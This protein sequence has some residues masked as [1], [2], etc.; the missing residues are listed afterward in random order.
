MAHEDRISALRAAFGERVR[1]LLTDAHGTIHCTTDPD[2]LVRLC[3]FL[4]DSDA[5]RCVYLSDLTAID[6][7]EGAPAAAAT[8]GDA[9]P[10]DGEGTPSPAK[11]ATPSK[12]EGHPTLADRGLFVVYCLFSL[13]H[14]FT[15]EIKA[16]VD[17]HRPVCPSVTKIWPA[18]NWFEREVYDLFGVEFTGHPD[19][20][21]ILNPPNWDGHPLRKSYISKPLTRE[22]IARLVGIDPVTMQP[23]GEVPPTPYE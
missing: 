18:A 11:P 5:F 2:T 19:L 14:R 13:Q 7:G 20:R 1:G 8:N 12:V 21:R 23:I 17:Y 3:E 9:A 16:P 4:N 10:S 15:I 6:L 22:Q